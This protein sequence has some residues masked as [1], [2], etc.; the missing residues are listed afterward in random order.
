MSKNKN[1]I[2]FF[3]LIDIFTEYSTKK[4]FESHFM[5][6]VAKGAS[7]MPPLDYEKRFVDFIYTHVLNN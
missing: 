1:E 6:I 3:G 7:S 2:Y 5:N 4:M